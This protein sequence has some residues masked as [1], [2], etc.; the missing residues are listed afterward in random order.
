MTTSVTHDE[1]IYLIPGR[2]MPF[3][4]KRG[5]IKKDLIIGLVGERGGG[6]SGSGATISLIDFMFDGVPCY[7]NMSIKCDIEID[8]AT[9]QKYGLKRGGVAHFASLPIDYK[10][11][12]RFDECYANS[13]IFLD[14]IN[15]ELSEARRSMSN[16]NLFFNR[17][18]QEL[19]HLQSSLIYTSISEMYLDSR[20]REFT[21]CFLR[22]EDTAYDSEGI[23]S[24]K[25]IGIDFKWVVYFMNRCFTGVTY[26]QT[27]RHSGE[28][29]FHFKPWRGIYDDKQFQGK[30][31]RKYGVNILKDDSTSLTLSGVGTSPS[32]V[33]DSHHNK[34]GFLE[35]IVDR[36]R[37]GGVLMVPSSRIWNEPEVLERRVAKNDIT[38]E[39]E[40]TY[41]IFKTRRNE[42][43]RKVEYYIFEKPIITDTGPQS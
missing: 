25:P 15:V 26:Q 21:D 6:K 19:R 16:T 12:L 38:L 41:K 43:L 22:C 3:L 34:W 36:Y 1:V 24:K 4:L 8:D 18:A 14:E 11:L 31:M 40:R 37:R 27:R 5:G 33:V 32:P 7:S 29:Y 20:L 2:E 17:V 9:A 10:K 13:L 23:R 30:D 35:G 39:L 28:V 42:G